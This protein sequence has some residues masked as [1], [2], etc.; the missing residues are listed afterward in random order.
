MR[1]NVLYI[2]TIIGF[3]FAPP[4]VLGQG[5]ERT[6]NMVFEVFERIDQRQADYEEISAD[7]DA[8]LARAKEEEEEAAGRFQKAQRQGDAVAVEK[9]RADLVVAFARQLSANQRG[10]Q[11]ILELYTAN[12]DDLVRLLPYL[13]RE[14]RRG[15]PDGRKDTDRFIRHASTFGPDV[16][17][18]LK[19][20][21]RLA[22][23]TRDPLLR[24]YLASTAASLRALEQEVRLLKTRQ[25]LNGN[26]G[27]LLNLV[28]GY[29]TTFDSAIAQLAV[30]RKLMENQEVK[31]RILNQ[32]VILKI[33]TLRAG[34][35]P[36]RPGT[37]PE[38]LG[39]IIRGTE[40]LDRK[41]DLYMP[42]ED[43]E[44]FDLEGYIDA[45]P[46]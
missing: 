8:E 32:L 45:L 10:V 33:L 40:E 3:L 25:S 12:R 28:K 31:L 35:G 20:Y 27:Q 7:L 30:A 19:Y 42:L 9:A 34:M 23:D 38:I 36:L 44:E 5:I 41:M 13:E 46:Y 26:A 39:K 6:S 29:I 2:T 21:T 15:G 37:P 16:K 17:G 11:H 14:A 22:R 1:K 18:M 43:G 4:K 24:S